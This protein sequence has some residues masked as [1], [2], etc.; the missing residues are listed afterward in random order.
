MSEQTELKEILELI[1]RVSVAVDGNES[2]FS[3][4]F[5][6]AATELRE[7]LKN[8]L[9]AV[10]GK[11]ASM[12]N[13][14]VGKANTA[15]INS[16]GNHRLMI[17]RLNSLNEKEE[18][19]EKIT[20]SK[21]LLAKI[22]STGKVD[23]IADG[24][25]GLISVIKVIRGYTLEVETFYTK[26]LEILKAI[27]NAKSTE[28]IVKITNRL[29]ELKF[30][31]CKLG[32]QKDTMSE[33]DLLPGGK[34][35]KFNSKT[36]KLTIENEVVDSVECVQSFDKNDV[37][38]IINNMLNLVGYYQDVTKANTKY[39]GY[40]KDFNTVV[41]KSFA[42]LEEI[43]GDVSISLVRDLESRLEGNQEV[44]AF[45][46]SFLPKVI[47]YL[48]DYVNTVSSFFSKQFN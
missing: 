3:E 37:K 26:E 20:F 6:S 47:I 43:K 29:D 2:R 28:D 24:V 32:N 27:S 42:H 34:V 8:G 1:Q 46:A 40:V 30:P 10:T 35:I 45:F 15:I 36:N 31:T 18:M 19:H 14:A 5:M 21:S 41:G 9:S 22:T 33:T 17:A 16:L 12:L 39:M 4:I 23:D 11:S 13:N 25:T 44:F 7:G 38:S 48:D